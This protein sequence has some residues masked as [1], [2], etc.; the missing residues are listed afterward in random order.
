MATNEVFMDIPEVEKIAKSFN[1]FGDA[2]TTIANTLQVISDGLKATAWLSFGA[3]AAVAAFIDGI[4]PSVKAAASEMR[5]ISQAVLQA[6][7]AYQT[8]DST[9]A[10][11][12][13]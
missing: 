2:L 5:N 3:T 13:I 6:I 8:G 1:Q 12:F 4:L 10:G 9:A 7:K 11:R